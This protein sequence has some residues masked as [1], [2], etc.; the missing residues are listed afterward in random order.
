VKIGD[1]RAVG[2]MEH[3]NCVVPWWDTLSMGY[4][5][6]NQVEGHRVDNLVEGTWDREPEAQSAVF[7]WIG[8]KPRVDDPQFGDR[9][10]PF[11]PFHA[12]GEVLSV[13]LSMTIHH[14]PDSNQYDILYTMG[15]NR[16]HPCCPYFL[17]VVIEHKMSF[18]RAV[19]K[20]LNLCMRW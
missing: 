6:G 17:H 1:Q 15:E 4:K 20:A 5:V 19:K 7:Q 12:T 14:L 18:S 11:C 2:V 16:Y 8:V 10:G 9:A 3:R 13:D